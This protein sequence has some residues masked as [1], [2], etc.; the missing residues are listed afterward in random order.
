V[1]PTKPGQQQV[2]GFPLVLLIGWVHPPL[3][4]ATTETVADLADQELQASAPTGPCRLDFVSESLGA[5][6]DFVLSLPITLPIAP[7]PPRPPS[8]DTIGL[9]CRHGDVYAGDFISMVQGN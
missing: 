2:I 5:V 8:K 1:V 6:P 9:L 4:T 7:C 3:F